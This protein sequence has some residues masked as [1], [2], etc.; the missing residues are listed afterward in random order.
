MSNY[1][2]GPWSKEEYNDYT[3][4]GA[5]GMKVAECAYICTVKDG[6]SDFS[7][8]TGNSHLIA[9]APELLTLLE[10]LQWNHTQKWPSDGM[11]HHVC[12]HCENT[13]GQGHKADC[14]I[15]ATIAKAK[16]K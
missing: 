15:G 3:I 9:A 4:N 10:E 6:K 16:G 8:M 12:P 7:E 14:Q 13:P 5:D 1:T 11:Y 2:P